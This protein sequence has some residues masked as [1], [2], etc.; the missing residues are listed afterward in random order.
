MQIPD[1]MNPC[2]WKVFTTPELE[3]LMVSVTEARI[4]EG[5]F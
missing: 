2:K 3:N 5:G 1:P 4:G